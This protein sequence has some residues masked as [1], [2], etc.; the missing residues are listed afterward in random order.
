DHVSPAAARSSQPLV[1]VVG[2]IA[3]TQGRTQDEHCGG[4]RAACGE[5]H[6]PFHDPW[7]RHRE[8][9][10]LRPLPLNLSKPTACPTPAPRHPT[11][12]DEQPAR[13][14]R[15]TAHTTNAPHAPRPHRDTPR[16]AT[17]IHHASRTH[18]RPHGDHSGSPL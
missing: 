1:E 10:S 13:C 6:A 12:L 3:T 4:D 2:G 16:A 9:V 18:P 14:F 17:D 11:G 8:E 7:P 15:C 5:L